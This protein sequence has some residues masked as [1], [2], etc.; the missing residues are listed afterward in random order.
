MMFSR[1]TPPVPADAMP[2]CL[3]DDACPDAC[4]AAPRR[5]SVSQDLIV[6]QRCCLVRRGWMLARCPHPAPR[7][8]QCFDVFETWRRPTRRACGWSLSCVARSLLDRALYTTWLEEL[9]Q[10][11]ILS[12]AGIPRRMV[13]SNSVSGFSRAHRLSAIVMDINLFASPARKGKEGRF[14]SLCTWTPAALC[15]TGHA[16]HGGSCSLPVG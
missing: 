2:V 12:W 10:D 3:R 11:Q 1:K 9:H 6:R 8:V 13:S 15:C 4:A 7:P 14:S 5:T 16:G